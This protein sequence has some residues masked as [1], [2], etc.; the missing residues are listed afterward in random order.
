ML[1]EISISQESNNVKNNETKQKRFFSTKPLNLNS[2]PISD[3]TYYSHRFSQK[4]SKALDSNNSSKN[5]L[6]TTNNTSTETNKFNTITN[7]NYNYNHEETLKKIQDNI[8]EPM[9][10]KKN[11]I[12]NNS[13]QLKNNVNLLEINVKQINLQLN[14]S[15][16]NNN[17]LIIES[18][19]FRCDYSEKICENENLEEEINTLKIINKKLIDRI[20][21]FDNQTFSIN[22]FNKNNFE[23][24]QK[25]K[26]E[27]KDIKEQIKKLENDIKNNRSIIILFNGKSNELKVELENFKNK[28]E[29]V[30]K[31]FE[32]LMKQFY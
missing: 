18:N 27:I 2:I 9:H 19:K 13:I 21:Y 20:N 28:N 7:F 29:L 15:N 17:N 3:R 23:E 14:N 8:I 31:G 16:S 5:G 25:M 12:R 22:S 6:L 24:I 10:K 30:G 32:Y 26:K 11:T 4:L 1:K